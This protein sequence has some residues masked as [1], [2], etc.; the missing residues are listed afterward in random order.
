MLPIRFSASVTAGDEKRAAWLVVRAGRGGNVGVAANRHALLLRCVE[1]FSRV[2][3]GYLR[4]PLFVRSSGKQT[5]TRRALAEVVRRR[6]AMMLLLLL[7]RCCC[8]C[9]M[10][11]LPLGDA[12]T[13]GERSTLLFVRLPCGLR[14]IVSAESRRF[15]SSMEDGM[16]DR[17]G[18]STLGERWRTASSRVP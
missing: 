16:G 9:G 8:C 15:P 13:L 10:L 14:D 18:V 11:R 4:R 17:V 2:G 3:R 7:P 12:R 6:L 1:A 5:H